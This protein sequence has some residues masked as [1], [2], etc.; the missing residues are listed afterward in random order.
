MSLAIKLI[1]FLVA[2]SSTGMVLVKTDLE[3]FSKKLETRVFPSPTDAA[4]EE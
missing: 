3:P 1:S 4:L 2:L